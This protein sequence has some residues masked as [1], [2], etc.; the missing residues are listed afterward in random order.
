MKRSS[1]R[2]CEVPFVIGR[3]FA[4]VKILKTKMK[5]VLTLEPCEIFAYMQTLILSIL[6]NSIGCA[7]IQNLKKLN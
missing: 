3:G 2:L 6:P 5:L 4:E 1:T 7:E